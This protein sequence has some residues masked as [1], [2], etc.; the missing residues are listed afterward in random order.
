MQTKRIL[1][2]EDNAEI[3]AN[4]VEILEIEGYQVFEAENGFNGIVTAA[5]SAFDLILIDLMLPDMYGLELVSHLKTMPRLEHVPVV[6]L[7]ARVIDSHGKPV[8][9]DMCDALLFK[10]FGADELVATVQRFIG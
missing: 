9:V 5:D 4:V 1:Y 2:V 6:A 3:R 7:T 8:V 10:P